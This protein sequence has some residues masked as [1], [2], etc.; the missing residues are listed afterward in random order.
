VA[1]PEL[2]VITE[3]DCI[4]MYVH[5]Y[6]YFDLLHVGREISE[7]FVRLFISYG[8]TYFLGFG[9]GFFRLV[10]SRISPVTCH[11]KFTIRFPRICTWKCRTFTRCTQ[12]H[13]HTYTHAHTHKRAHSRGFRGKSVISNI[14]YRY[15]NM[16]KN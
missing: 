2:F 10:N 5:F 6:S 1:G 13:T 3:F 9:R 4:Y 12:A 14:E 16:G 11:W 8:F 7:I 15:E